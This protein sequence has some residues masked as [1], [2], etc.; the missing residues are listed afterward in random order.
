MKSVILFETAC[1]APKGVCWAAKDE[2]FAIF[3]RF[4]AK[5]AMPD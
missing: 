2:N 5:P 1:R 3:V 4:S